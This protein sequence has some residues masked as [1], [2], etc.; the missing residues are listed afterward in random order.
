[1]LNNTVMRFPKP[2][3]LEPEETAASLDHWQTQ[4]KVYAKRDPLMA[5]FLTGTWNPEEENMGYT[6]A[7]NGVD[8]VTRGENCKLFLSHLASFLKVPYYNLAIQ[9]RT[10]SLESVWE[11]L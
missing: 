2:R 11:F 9:T 6:E 7:L 1:M 8:P 3:D 4:F 10:T 5:P